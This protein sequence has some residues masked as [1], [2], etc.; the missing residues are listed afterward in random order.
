MKT[1]FYLG[2]IRSGSTFLT[3]LIQKNGINVCCKHEPYPDMFG[4][5]I[6]WKAIGEKNLIKQQF[7]KKKSKIESIKKDKYIECNHAFIKSFSDVA[8]EFFPDM[9]LIR[10]IR[11]PLQVAKS[12]LNKKKLTE[13]LP[14]FLKYYKIKHEKRYWRWMLTGKEAVFES[15]NVKDLSLFQFYVLEWIEIENRIQKFLAFYNKDCFTLHSPND[16]N[17][18]EKLKKMFCFLDIELRDNKIRFPVRK[19]ANHIKTIITDTD[20]KEFF[21]IIDKIDKNYLKI[22][23]Q[24]PYN[25]Y[26]WSKLL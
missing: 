24:T 4:L 25:E 22:F 23:K 11:N 17:N 9:K 20:K 6:Y 8:M 19:N 2:N 14:W 16:L 26:L 18:I 13:L 5:P 12:A 1:I 15:F 7:L 21:E 3:G 10:T